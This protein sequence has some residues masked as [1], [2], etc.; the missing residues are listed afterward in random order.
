MLGGVEPMQVMKLL[1]VMMI[2]QLMIRLTFLKRMRMKSVAR[3]MRSKCMWLRTPA[4]TWRPPAMPTQGW[5]SCTGCSSLPST[6][7][8][9]G[10][11]LS[12]LLLGEILLEI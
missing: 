11:R 7:P 2:L 8:A 3:R 9:I 12:S 4:L 10:W 5:P 1:L 6:A